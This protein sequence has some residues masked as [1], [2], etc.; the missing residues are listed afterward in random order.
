MA[1]QPVHASDQGRINIPDGPFLDA[2]GNISP[3]WRIWLLNPNVQTL[4]VAAPLTAYN[5]GTGTS[6]EPSTGDVLVANS[7]GTYTPTSLA[8]LSAISS[9]PMSSDLRVNTLTATAG[10]AT[11]SLKVGIRTVTSDYTLAATDYVVLCDSTSGTL[12]V[13]MPSAVELAGEFFVLKRIDSG[14]NIITLQTTGG[15]TI[16]GMSAIVLGGWWSSVCV[17]SNGSQWYTVSLADNSVNAGGYQIQNGF[18]VNNNAN[19]SVSNPKDSN[20]LGVRGRA[21]NSDLGDCYSMGYMQIKSTSENINPTLDRLAFFVG[22]TSYLNNPIFSPNGT[23]ATE[24][25]SIQS[26]GAFNI[27]GGAEF[28]GASFAYTKEVV[29]SNMAAA[30]SGTPQ[31][32]NYVG[33]R[34]RAWNSAQGNEATLG[35]MQMINITNNANPTVDRL[36]FFVGSAD[37]GNEPLYLFG[38][39]TTPAERFC[40]TTQGRIGIGITAPSASL[41]ILA[42]TSAAN[43]APLKFNSGALNTTAEAG[44]V[45]FLTDDYFATVTTGAAR[46]AIA[47]CPA[48]TDVTASRVLNTTYTAPATRSV[49]VHATVR[50][51]I[52]LA[53]GNAYVQ[54]KSD[55]SSPPTTVASGIVGIQAGLLNE[56]NS[57]QISFV[58][59][60]GVNYRIDSATTNGTT[61]LGKW[62][63]IA[64]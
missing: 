27:A 38:S 44:A 32:S 37:F 52:T 57:F 48:Q 56:D 7:D 41:H 11:Q 4:D 21:W 2:R 54:G 45:E 51:A 3:A 18:F 43:T 60:A 23:S 42:G 55:S 36:A 15:Q 19:S 20:V 16:D 5:G 10:I 31:S 6:T 59:A 40:A 39:P 64:F 9:K 25:M 34:G 26:D 13:T 50:C 8:G 62:F 47:F 1:T 46:K 12:R 28:K 30:T 49:M 58:V 53:G 35:W 17:V 61:T 24:Q 14:T 33:V 63:E 22:S 29:A